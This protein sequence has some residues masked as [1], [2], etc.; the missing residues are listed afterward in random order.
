[1]WLGLAEPARAAGEWRSTTAAPQNCQVHVLGGVV[2]RCACLALCCIGV[3]PEELYRAWCGVLRRMSC[4]QDRDQPACSEGRCGG[5]AGAP[6]AGRGGAA[7]AAGALPRCRL[8]GGHSQVRAA[9]APLY[10]CAAKQVF[11][12]CSHPLARM[13]ARG[14]SSTRYTSLC[15]CADDMRI[16]Y[17]TCM[18]GCERSDGVRAER[19]ST[20]W[21]ATR[22]SFEALTHK[23]PCD[24]FRKHK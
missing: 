2:R 20:R 24:Q 12:S 5:R 6:A 19:A 9:R 18:R 13:L 4:M 14:A 17:A 22:A 8:R 7:S 21:M 23:L 15:A 11:N 10:T 1:M 3:L 16:A